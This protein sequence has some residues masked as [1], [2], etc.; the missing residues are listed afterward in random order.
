M[1][2]YFMTIKDLYQFT[3]GKHSLVDE[4]FKEI[5]P[6]IIPNESGEYKISEL[7][8]KKIRALYNRKAKELYGKSA[9]Q[10]EN[11]LDFVILKDSNN[12]IIGTEFMRKDD[13]DELKNMIKL[14]HLDWI[15]I[16]DNDNKEKYKIYSA[17]YGDFN[18]FRKYEKRFLSTVY[19]GNEEE[20]AY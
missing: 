12:K 2:N 8:L 7:E 5:C 10:K 11:D 20:M 14:S 18:T 16:I 3:C 19:Y 17:N 1:R 6:N 15:L 9:T 13:I 4:S